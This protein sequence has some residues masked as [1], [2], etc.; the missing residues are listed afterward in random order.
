MTTTVRYRQIVRY[1]ASMSKRAKNRQRAQSR[2]RRQQV[3]G[4]KSAGRMSRA[5]QEKFD[6]ILN[7]GYRALSSGQTDR[8]LRQFQEALSIH[9]DDDRALLGYAQSLGTNARFERIGTVCACAALRADD[10]RRPPAFLVGFPRSG[11]TMTE[12][13]LATHPAIVTTDEAPLISQ[14]GAVAADIAGCHPAEYL[15]SF[16]TD[17]VAR[18]RLAY[19]NAAEK[20]FGNEIREHVFLDKLPLNIVSLW[21]INLVFPQSKII[22]ALRDPRDVCISNLLQHFG[23]NSSM[24]H[25]LRL[26]TTVK[27]YCAVMDLYLH[28]RDLVSLD[29][30]ETRYEDTVQDLEGQARRMLAHLGLDWDESVLRFYERKRE[31]L[32][33]TPSY[34]AVTESVHTR[35]VGRWKNYAR[36]FEPYLADLDRF[37]KAFGYDSG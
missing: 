13:I 23:M 20:A 12:Q 27:F 34:A 17:D 1:N 32:I 31:R 25:M 16:T 14:V 15:D 19:W 11:T 30:I 22:V 28:M 18:L 24:I 29:M 9:S 10:T 35:S 4:A 7:E 26:E 8:V 33:S 2:S 5:Q 21:L 36:H 3:G 6:S 37:V